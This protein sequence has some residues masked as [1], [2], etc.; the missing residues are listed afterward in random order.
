MEKS[1]TIL[2]IADT[3]IKAT[4][5]ALRK[6]SRNINANQIILITSKNLE[7]NEIFKSLE[8]INVNPINTF[9]KYNNFVIYELY[10][11]I[12]TSHV[13][14]IQ[15]DGFILNHKK[16]HDSFLDYDYIGAPFIPRTQD[17]NYCRNS[18]GAF[19]SIGNGGFSIRSLKLLEAA[20]KYNLKDNKRLTENHE[21]GF[22][23]V[24]HRDFLESKGFKWANF[25][26]ASKFAIESPLMMKEI[27]NLPFGFHGKKILII[28]P[29]LKLLKIFIDLIKKSNNK[30]NLS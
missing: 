27:L 8:I 18:N 20:K 2:A 24:Y 10:K 16:W 13:L 6:S 12:K 21:D 30:I 23:C 1:L 25:S 7:N 19:Y 3:K 11:Y 15:W 14:L 9:K 5:K 26:L 4:I 29:L 28:Y 17:P 22:Y